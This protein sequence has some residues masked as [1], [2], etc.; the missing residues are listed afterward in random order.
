MRWVEGMAGVLAGELASNP[1]VTQLLAQLFWCSAAAGAVGGCCCRQQRCAAP[2]RRA[3]VGVVTEGEAEHHGGV[4]LQ[5]SC[6]IQL[7]LCA[8]EVLQAGGARD[9]VKVGG[10]A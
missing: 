8:L 5:G 10:K 4:Q 2:Q 7:W 1:L 3:D 6:H 9:R